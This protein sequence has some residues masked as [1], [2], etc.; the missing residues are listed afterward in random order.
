MCLTAKTLK[1]NRSNTMHVCVLSSFSHVRLIDFLPMLLGRLRPWG[2]S[3]QE[4]L[5][6]LPC[7]PPGD[8]LHPGIKPVSLIS[9]TLAGGFFTISATWEAPSNIV[10]IQ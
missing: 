5:S 8:L 1:H 7:P 4:Y 9:P 2:F 6:G 10:Q 3:R